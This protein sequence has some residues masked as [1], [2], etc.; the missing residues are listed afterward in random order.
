[1]KNKEIISKEIIHIVPEDGTEPFDV[2]EVEYGFDVEFPEDDFTEG[3]NQ[4][5]T[6]QRNHVAIRDAQS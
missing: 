1:M 3:G 4:C 5:H 6:N 2:V